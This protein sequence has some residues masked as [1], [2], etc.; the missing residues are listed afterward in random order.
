MKTVLIGPPGTGK[1]TEIVDWTKRA[2]R[3]GHSPSSIVLVAFAR[4]SAQELKERVGDSRLECVRTIHS[5]CHRL[6]GGYK[7]MSWYN[8]KEF[9]DT[10]KYSLSGDVLGEDDDVE[11]GRRDD[12][13]RSA[14][15]LAM[16][17]M[18]SIEEACYM[19]QANVI[20]TA[21][22]ERDLREYKQTKGVIEHDDAIV[23]VLRRGLSIRS[24]LF[25][26]DEAQDLSP[27]QS[28]AINL[29]TENS[30]C[31]VLVGDDD[32]AVY[33]F[34]GADGELMRSWIDGGAQKLELYQ[35][36]R[37]PR[38]VHALAERTA[39]EISNRIPRAFNPRDADGSVAILSDARLSRKLLEK[40][41]LVLGRTKKMLR[42]VARDLSG[43]GVPF[44]S[45]IRNLSPLEVS[46][47]ANTVIDLME[48]R[49]V[50]KFDL[51]EVRRVLGDRS[52]ASTSTFDGVE[53][54]G[55]NDLPAAVR[56]EI[57][58]KGLG[59]LGKHGA[60]LQKLHRKFGKIPE[61]EIELSTIHGAKGREREVVYVLNDWA[62]RPAAALRNSK[63]R[64]SEHR[65][66]Y[67]AVTRA[68]NE[69]I[70]VSTQAANIYPF[71]VRTTGTGQ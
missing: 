10:F 62:K 42:T 6:V 57:R 71:V 61:A 1:T 18:I 21:C 63:T 44:L 50:T 12:P 27:L 26:V 55:I 66:A 23:E 37:L 59:A 56:E 7:P 41:G 39:Q 4:A 48:G 40:P 15:Q 45:R 36:H 30:P 29:W 65:V 8:W 38:A 2:L 54:A 35:S 69:L 14:H 25:V 58:K 32:Q 19:H 47:A 17:R 53:S 3:D 49:S 28:A 33:D 51:I 46:A 11:E 5:L 16:S 52:A 22:F 68:R 34:A 9:A 31:S 24:S 13:V 43:L 67:V 70:V 64:D 60:A 20:R